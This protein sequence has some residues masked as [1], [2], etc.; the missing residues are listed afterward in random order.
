MKGL[1]PLGR[2]WLQPC[3]KGPLMQGLQPLRKLPYPRWSYYAIRNEGFNPRATT[4][5]LMV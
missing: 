4:T 2:A 3:R 5:I 1:Q